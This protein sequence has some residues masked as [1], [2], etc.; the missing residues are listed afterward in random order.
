MSYLLSE[1]KGSTFYWNSTTF[2]KKFAKK[3]AR[4]KKKYY[5]CTRNQDKD[6]AIAQLVEQRTEN[7]CVP[8]SIPGGT[9]PPFITPQFSTESS[10][11][12]MRQPLA[13]L[14]I[15]WLNRMCKSHVM[16]ANAIASCRST[17]WVIRGKS[18]YSNAK[19]PELSTCLWI[20]AVRCVHKSVEK[21]PFPLLIM[22]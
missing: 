14:R 2:L 17:A 7:P 21:H 13:R 5:L 12:F 15:R 10:G 20:T 4:L 8:G 16:N 3:V 9:T 18:L 1:C 6:G 22:W 19:R 11:F